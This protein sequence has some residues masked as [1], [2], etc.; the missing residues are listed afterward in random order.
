MKKIMAA[1]IAQKSFR[2]LFPLWS[3][4]KN[5]ILKLMK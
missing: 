5:N 1:E 4:K 2:A 3:L